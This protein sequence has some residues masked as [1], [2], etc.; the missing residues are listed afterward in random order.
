MENISTYQ[1]IPIRQLEQ[2]KE[3]IETGVIQ[4]GDDWPMIAIRGD[5][6]MYYALVLSMFLDG[7]LNEND[8]LM[9]YQLHNLLKLLQSCNV[10]NISQENKMLHKNTIED[11]QKVLKQIA[12]LGGNLSDET[13]IERTGPNDA[14]ARGLMYTEAR[15]LALSMLNMSLHDIFHDLY[16]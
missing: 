15:K 6:A 5:N 4:F 9:K 13:L 1:D 16:K 10:R 3:R 7:T 8:S 12:I 2:Q 11:Y 14:V